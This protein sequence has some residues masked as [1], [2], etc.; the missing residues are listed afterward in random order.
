MRPCVVSIFGQD[1]QRHSLE[2][3]ADSLFAAAYAGLEQWAK[4]WWLFGC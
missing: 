4:L 3:K 1:G 2:T